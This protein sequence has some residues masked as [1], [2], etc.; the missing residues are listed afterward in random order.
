VALCGCGR[1]LSGDGR[2]QGVRDL[3]SEPGQGRSHFISIYGSSVC[4]EMSVTVVT[5]GNLWHIHIL[6]G[7]VIFIQFECTVHVRRKW[8]VSSSR[9]HRLIEL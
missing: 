3:N 7:T 5:H 9:T 8:E 1:P 6:Y 2:G 4:G